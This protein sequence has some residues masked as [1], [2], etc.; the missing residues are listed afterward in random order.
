MTNEFITRV[1]A[2]NSQRYNQ[3]YSHDLTVD[4]LYEEIGELYESTE[5]VDKLDALV[6]IV[7]VVVG[8]MW[9][10]GLTEAQIVQAIHVVCDSN[11]SKRIDNNTPSHIKANLD[12]GPNF[13]T[14]EPKLQEIL[15]ERH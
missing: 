15:N 13:I 4:L 1:I 11:A 3:E 2:W 7:Y 14:P 6:D 10:L 12:K 5:D 9:K 8:A